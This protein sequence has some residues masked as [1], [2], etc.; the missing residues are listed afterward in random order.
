MC[1]IK[2]EAVGFIPGRSKVKE[3]LGDAK[4]HFQIDKMNSM[5]WAASF[6]SMFF[7]NIYV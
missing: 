7:T 1:R 2:A 3:M 5:T 4:M 6:Q